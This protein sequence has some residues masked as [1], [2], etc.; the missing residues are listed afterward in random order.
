MTLL[1]MLKIGSSVT[2]VYS[3]IVSYFKDQFQELAGEWNAPIPLACLLDKEYDEERYLALAE[4]FSE[5]Y[6]MDFDYSF[7]E[8]VEAVEYFEEEISE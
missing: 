7:E 2:T 5:Q 1:D 8:F 3:Q 4:I 6:F